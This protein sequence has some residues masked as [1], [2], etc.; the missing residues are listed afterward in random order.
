MLVYRAAM[1]SEPRYVESHRNAA[2]L[3]LELGRTNDAIARHR[4]VLDLDAR[5]VRARRALIQSL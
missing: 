1:S 2:A 4:I 3:F 5:N